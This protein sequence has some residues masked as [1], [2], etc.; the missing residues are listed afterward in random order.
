MIERGEAIDRTDVL[1]KLYS[2]KDLAGKF[3]KLTEMELQ[4]AAT[5]D[6][7]PG[8]QNEASRS[9]ALSH[10]ACRDLMG[11]PVLNEMV[12]DTWGASWTY[13][14]RLHDGHVA[15]MKKDGGGAAFMLHYW[16]GVKLLLKIFNVAGGEQ[17]LTGAESFLER[18]KDDGIP[19]EGREE[20][21]QHW[22]AL[23]ANEQQ[24][25]VPLRLY[26]QE[27]SEAFEEILEEE[28]GEA[29]VDDLDGEGVT[30]TSLGQDYESQA[31]V[32]AVRN[33]YHRF[34]GWIEKKDAHHSRL[35]A[36]SLRLYAWLPRWAV[37]CG[38]D[39]FFPAAILPTQT[40]LT[41]IEKKVSGA[42]DAAG[43]CLVSV[44]S[45]FDA[46]WQPANSSRPPPPTSRSL[47][48]SRSWS[49]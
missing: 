42:H 9:G 43:V 7:R 30:S 31:F 20:A 34:A 10:K 48:S 16:T 11:H 25:P 49:S 33:T 3:G 6:V 46:T 32:E 27:G 12:M 39:R 41:S 4:W 2:V 23:H 45:F 19:A 36:A 21:V 5:I 40:R 24:V 1:D 35:V 14:K 26:E 29:G 13:N 17:G 8:Q 47:H 37:G 15:A 28:L 44:L 18:V 38:D 22:E